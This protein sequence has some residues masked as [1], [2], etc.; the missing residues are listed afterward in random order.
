[1]LVI[2]TWV[3]EMS[4]ERNQISR[5]KRSR[6]EAKRTYDRYSR[7]YDWIGGQFE[8]K[9][10][11]TGVQM[12]DIQPGEHI[13]E[14]GYGTGHILTLLAQQVGPSGTVS[15]IDISKGMFEITQRRIQK[16]G[17]Q[18]QVELLCA[19]F[20]AYPFEAKSK[21]VIFMSFTLE[22]F[23]TP[24]IPLVL[25]KCKTILRK[26]GRIGIVALSKKDAEGIITKLYEGIHHY[27][28]QWVDCRPIFLSKSV[29]ENG[30]HLIKEYQMSMYGLLVELIVATRP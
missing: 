18:S 22:L 2:C 28:P 26:G 1:M 30:F 13:L 5:V 10:A 20:I 9:Y 24:E 8:R 19:D 14:I 16:M 25:S 15:G 21:D 7:F 29:T 17:L 6:I 27:F 23:D 11:L 3:N 4:I 12:L